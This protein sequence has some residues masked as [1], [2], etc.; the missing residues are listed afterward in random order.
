MFTFRIF[1]VRFYFYFCVKF[2]FSFGFVLGV[3]LN[4]LYIFDV[5]SYSY[6]LIII[7]DL[8]MVLVV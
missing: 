2:R 5:E 6:T 3:F 4:K 8:R 7:L 1:W